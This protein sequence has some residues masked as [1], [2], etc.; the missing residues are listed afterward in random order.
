MYE[1]SM[2]GFHQRVKGVAVIRVKIDE[3]GAFNFRVS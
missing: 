2:K 1:S 3:S